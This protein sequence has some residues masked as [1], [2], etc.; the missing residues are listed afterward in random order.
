MKTNN[1]DNLGTSASQC[2]RI[3]AYMEQGKS[4]TPLEALSLFSCFRLGAR[5][6]DLK[7]KGHRII[8]RKVKDVVTGKRFASYSLMDDEINNCN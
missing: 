5:I 1:N 2:Q 8:S 4:I 6:A 7:Q 3:L